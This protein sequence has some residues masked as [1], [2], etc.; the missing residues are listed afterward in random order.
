MCRGSEGG[1][2]REGPSQEDTPSGRPRL[3]V[4][5]LPT[6]HLGRYVI[7]SGVQRTP[8]TCP[9]IHKSRDQNPIHETCLNGWTYVSNRP[10]FLCV[11]TNETKKKTKTQ[12]QYSEGETL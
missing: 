11:C 9:T 10:I 4:E 3:R 8:L 1:P 12:K 5:R 2:V 6:P 7:E